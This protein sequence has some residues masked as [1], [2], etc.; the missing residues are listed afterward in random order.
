MLERYICYLIQFIRIMKEKDLRKEAYCECK[1][2]QRKETLIVFAIIAGIGILVGCA[3]IPV[4]VWFGCGL[5]LFLIAV[6][7]FFAHATWKR[8]QTELHA[9]AQGVLAEA[10]VMELKDEK[11]SDGKLATMAVYE[12]ALPGGSKHR[13]KEPVSSSMAGIF[14]QIRVG[15]KFPIFFDRNNPDIFY[16]MK[17]RLMQQLAPDMDDASIS[18]YLGKYGKSLDGLQPEQVVR[19]Y[20]QVKWI[21]G[22]ILGPIIAGAL[23]VVGFA[24]YS[25]WQNTRHDKIELPPG[26]IISLIG[27]TEVY[28][29]FPETNEWSYF[30]DDFGVTRTACWRYDSKCRKPIQIGYTSISFTPQEVGDWP[31][32]LIPESYRSR[33]DEFA[34]HKTDNN[35]TPP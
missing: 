28:H 32:L 17:H 22:A 4:Y 14:G 2:S 26:V 20:K 31:E 19:A 34:A 9:I 35:L 25:N 21:L 29:Y 30:A 27:P 24:V 1:K 12:F 7:C 6:A 16:L 10:E 3:F 15:V 11:D 8:H 5:G 18:Q 13:F 23:G 33:L